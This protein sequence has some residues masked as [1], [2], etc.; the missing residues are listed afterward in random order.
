M[1]Y[2]VPCLL[3][4][5]IRPSIAEPAEPD[6]APAG[7]LSTLAEQTHWKRTGR[8]DEVIKLCHEFAAAYPTQV[9]CSQF[10]ESAEGRPLLALIVSA[11]GVL[12]PEAAKA[13]NRPVVFFQ[14][15]IH[16]G[17]ID[18]KDAGFL[19]LRE[20]LRGEVAPGVL[21]K[22]TL[23]F[24][25]VFNADGHERF[26]KNN[27]PNQRGPE[28]MGWRTTAQ[29]FNLNRDYTKADSP[30]MAAMLKLLHAWDPI[31]FLDLHVTD[32]AEFQHDV[33]LTVSPSAKGPPA[34]ARIGTRLSLRAKSLLESKGHLPILFFYPSFLKEDEPLSGFVA[35]VSSIRFSDGYWGMNSRL[36]VLV[37][38]HSWKEYGVRVKATHD[39]LLSCIEI[40]AEEADSW[41]KAAKQTDDEARTIGGSEVVLKYAPTKSFETIEFKGYRFEHI[42]SPVSGQLYTKYYPQEPQVWRVPF[43]SELKPSLTATAPKGGY[44]VPKAHAG[45]V[46]EKLKLHGINYQTLPAAIV[47]EA[48]AYR[49]AEFHFAPQSFEGHQALT[50]KGKWAKE[51]REVPAGSLFIPIAQPRARLI[52]FLFEPE[53]VE[54]FLS[55]GF[56]NAAFEIKE[57]VEPYVA[58]EIARDMLA[59]DPALRAE[60]ESVL[61]SHPEIAKDPEKRLEFFYRRHP[62]WDE[63]FALYPVLKTDRVDFSA[64]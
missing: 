38:T 43:Y 14:G 62:S 24:V 42:L 18:G 28:E 53:C 55:W 54:S 10:G 16:A 48:E 9:A 12:D 11:D 47:L 25:P 2:L 13:K 27:R 50:V 6:R 49:A 7:T 36:G 60:F 29:N 40:A 3:I 31:L 34:L 5:S 39:T 8:Y 20:L 44:L 21:S 58:E 59:R 32:G 45:W 17:E 37:E 35:R 57:Y 61:K 15:G 26:G 51:K 23:V 63:R 30:E 33:S 46:S 4:M 52:V 1:R 19:L 41:V 22:L 56:F 64:R